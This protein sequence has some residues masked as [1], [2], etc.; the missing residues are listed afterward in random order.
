MKQPIWVV[1][2]G[3]GKKLALSPEANAVIQD[4][5][6]L[7]GGQRLLAVFESHPA[8]KMPIERNLDKMISRLQAR[9][10]DEKIVILASGDPGFH[11]IAGTLLEH[12]PPG[13][14]RILPHISSLQAAFARAGLHWNDAVFTSAHAHSLAEVIGWARR[15]PKLGIL[16]DHA[17]TP[18]VIAETLLRAGVADCRAIVAE[19]LGAGDER[20]VDA[21]LSDLTRQEFAPLNVML[22][23][24]NPGWQPWPVFAPRDDDAYVHRRGLITKAD[25]RALCLGRLALRETDVVWDIG[26]GSGAVS[27]EMAEIAW[28]GRVFAIEKDPENLGY[29]RQNIERFGTLNVEVVPG[30]APATLVGLPPP[31]AVFIGG[32]G[33]QLDAILMQV[34]QSALPGCRVTATFALLE[35]VLQAQRWMKQAG[36]NPS[37]AQAQIAYGS[38]LAE[39]TRLS[40]LN[41][42]FILNGVIP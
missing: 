5:G 11:G 31:H 21:R 32:S 7:M 22:L 38:S 34:A 28:R 41:P 15:A 29:L 3:I 16:T 12:F 8:E 30:E 35:N 14:V 13:E 4:A 25:I 39:G 19:N 6:L 27:I 42:V 37:L 10:D 23:V 33:G 2:L 17:N 36:W 26:A 9:H 18:A 24:H 1:G 40:P 20:L